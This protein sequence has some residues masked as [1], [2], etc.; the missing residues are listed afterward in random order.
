MEIELK[1][2][3]YLASDRR[4]WSIKKRRYYTDQKTNETKIKNEVIGTGYLNVKEALISFG[5]MNVRMT[6]GNSFEDVIKAYDE[7][8][9]FINEKLK[10]FNLKEGE[11]VEKG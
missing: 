10:I 6:E 7:Y 2:N 4:K 5:E 11:Y 1:E 8:L 3:Y 9:R